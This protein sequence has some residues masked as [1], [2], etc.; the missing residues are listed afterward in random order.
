MIPVIEG[1]ISRL[2][3]PISIDT[4]KASVARVAVR[5]GAALINDVSMLEDPQMVRV[6]SD[7]GVPIILS[8]IRKNGH[9]DDVVN[10]VID[11]LR[12]AAN[13]L[14]KYT[15]PPAA[16]PAMMVICGMTPEARV[17]RLKISP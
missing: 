6:I 12:V 2:N 15:A 11:D 10:E 1:L 13:D 17:L 14:K 8:H 5:S 16:G 9:Q 3:I 4:R 7:M